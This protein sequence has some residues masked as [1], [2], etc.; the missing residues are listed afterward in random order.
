M[1]NGPKGP[2]K[3]Q[4]N[5]FGD[6]CNDAWNKAK[7]DQAPPGTYKVV[8]PILIECEN[9]IRTYIVTIEPVDGG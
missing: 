9:P 3:G 6:A 1:S 5:K 4:G 8:E 2:W 7:G